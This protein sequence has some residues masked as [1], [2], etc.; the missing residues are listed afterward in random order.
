MMDTAAGNSGNSGNSGVEAVKLDVHPPALQHSELCPSNKQQQSTNPLHHSLKSVKSVDSVSAIGAFP[1]GSL[2]VNDPRESDELVSDL[3]M[4][5]PTS[6]PACVSGGDVFILDD[7][8]ANFTIG[9][10]TTSFNSTQSF[11][12][13]RDIPPGVHL[14]W[15]A[16]SESTSSRSGYWIYT[17]EKD[18]TQP[19][20]VYV[21]QWDKFNEVLGDPASQAEERFQK[22]RLEQIFGTLS[23]YHLR[24]ASTESSHKLA[25]T[26]GDDSPLDLLG[27]KNIWYQL[28]FAI[29][30]A[31]LNRVTS[32]TRNTWHVTTMDSVAG[33]TGLA[34][35]AQL[36]ASGASHLRFTFPMDV[37][38]IDPEATG[39]D[40]T[41]QALDPTRWIINRLECP[42]GDHQPDDLIGE[43]Q[44]AFLAGMHLGNQSCLEQWFFLAT[45]VIFR[46][47]GLTID[48][49]QLARN[50][51]QTFHAQLLY[52]DRY[53]QGDV[54]ELMP[55]HARKLQLALTTYK[56]RLDETLLALGDLCT[57]DQHSVGVAFSSLE[58]WLWRLGWDLRGEYVRSGNVML[59]DGEI[60]Q[61]ELS[62]FEDEDERGEFA[63]T[64]VEMEN[65][66]EAG[67]LSW[68]A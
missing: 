40:R 62:D 27:D 29:H 26:Q 33:E 46:S 47:F 8:P 63:P 21:K 48:K 4:E 53:L 44:F 35:E 56:A 55:Q 7:L 51:I 45:R 16:P 25:L 22:E 24:A 57:P 1:L 36:Y 64:V 41:R 34:G 61:A 30:P 43:F 23:P 50:L 59:E 54:L 60:V 12:G 32:Q 13:F 2:R 14:I 49:P 15:V 66:R 6:T 31:L 3:P 11:P 28:T 67:L 65:G 37:R 17:P 18:P 39:A 42:D 58:S 20:H 19:G 38:L 10:D 68:D 52:N 9:C 5:N